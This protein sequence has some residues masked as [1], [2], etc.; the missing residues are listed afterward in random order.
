M[1]R[2]FFFYKNSVIQSVSEESSAPNAFQTYR[3]KK[4][5][6]YTQND[7]VLIMVYHIGFVILNA[8]KNL[9]RQCI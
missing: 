8:V 6:R 2:L 1:S 5:L 3:A 4:I 9:L 7:R